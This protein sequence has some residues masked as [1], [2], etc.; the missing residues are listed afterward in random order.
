MIIKADLSVLRS[1]K[2]CQEFQYVNLAI[3]GT[4]KESGYFEKKQSI[5]RGNGHYIADPLSWTGR[6]NPEKLRTSWCMETE[7][8]WFS[9]SESELCNFGY[10]SRV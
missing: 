2:V 6:L 10:P 5:L 3:T 9:V 8:R 1:L 7:K 4:I